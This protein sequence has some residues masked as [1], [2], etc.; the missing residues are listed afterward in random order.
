MARKRP[1]AVKATYDLVMAP[2]TGRAKSVGAVVADLATAG[3]IPGGRW[4]R[5]RPRAS[6]RRKAARGG[7]GMGLNREELRKAVR[8]EI[9]Q[10]M[11]TGK[12]AE[13]CAHY[14]KRSAM[15]HAGK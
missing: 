14:E 9:A 10:V 11:R 7:T 6:K 5:P 12:G 8:E 3:L 15:H 13:E 1:L 2:P 4:S